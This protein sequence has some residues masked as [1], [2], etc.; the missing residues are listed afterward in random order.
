MLSGIY[1]VIKSSHFHSSNILMCIM[2]MFETYVRKLFY[3]FFTTIYFH[4]LTL[5]IVKVFENLRLSQFRYYKPKSSIIKNL[6]I[7]RLS[8]NYEFTIKFELLCFIHFNNYKESSSKSRFI[9]IVQIFLYL[10]K[11]TFSHLIQIRQPFIFS[12]YPVTILVTA[13]TKTDKVNCETLLLRRA[14]EQSEIK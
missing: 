3:F 10:T 12:R 14:F 8:V 5:L 13:F 6:W 4:V 9:N 1:S 11:T 2:T 7:S